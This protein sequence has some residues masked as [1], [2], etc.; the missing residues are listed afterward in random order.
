MVVA[1]FDHKY[2]YWVE[3]TTRHIN[4]LKGMGRRMYD[5]ANP[6]AASKAIKAAGTALFKEIDKSTR[7]KKPQPLS[8]MASALQMLE[9]D[10]IEAFVSARARRTFYE[11]RIEERA[12]LAPVAEWWC[13]IKGCNLLGLGRI[14][15]ALGPG[16][17][18]SGKPSLSNY[19]TVSKMWRRLGFACNDDGTRQRK[20][21]GAKG[22]EQGFNPQRCAVVYG[23]VDSMFKH[24]GT[25]EKGTATEYRLV[26]EKRR[27]K[28]EAEMDWPKG[29][30]NNDAKRI[31]TK[32]LLLD[33]WRAW[34]RAKDAMITSE[35]VPAAGE[36]GGQPS[37]DNQKSNAPDLADI[38][39]AAE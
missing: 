36:E 18:D 22:E 33:L 3:T 21:R 37:V 26:Y 5:A 32:R 14:L 39:I 10:T 30:L 8:A 35:A 20:V 12:V 1:K 23:F 28:K 27:A 9:I 25:S 11:A 19:S 29:H 7:L 6:D 2:G 16:D 4:R 31:L 17:P 38:P 24:Q 15:A 34:R 13:G